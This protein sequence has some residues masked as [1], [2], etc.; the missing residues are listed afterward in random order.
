[1]PRRSGPTRRIGRKDMEYRIKIDD[2]TSAVQIEPL[3]NRLY[4]VSFT[5]HD[6]RVDVLEISENLYSLI[7]DGRSYEVDIMEAGDQYEIFVKG[8][9]Y[10]T[11][12]LRPEQ[13]IPLPAGEKEKIPPPDENSVTAPMNGK[14]IRVLVGAGEKVEIDQT[15]LILEA[16]KM[17]MPISSPFAGAVKEILVK[18]GQIVES[19]KVLVTLTRR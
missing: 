9:T 11:E 3:E 4:R 14:V 19:G 7:C 8:N 16:M 5:D 1:M 18:E 13:K 15:L 12:V 6:F 10:F 17:E 2:T